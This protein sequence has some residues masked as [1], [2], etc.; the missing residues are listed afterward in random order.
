MFDDWHDVGGDQADRDFEEKERAEF[1]KTRHTKL[2]AKC[3]KERK[4]LVD[5]GQI[6]TVWDIPIVTVWDSVA[7]RGV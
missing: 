3:H 7:R 1:F 2:C 6:K 5:G 4:K